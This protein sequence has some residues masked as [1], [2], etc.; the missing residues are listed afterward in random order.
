MSSGFISEKDVA[1][2]RRVRQENW[3]KNRK[4]DDPLEAPEEPPPD[5]RSLYDRLQEQRQ[6]KQE[7]YDEAHKK[8]VSAMQKNCAEEEMRA[9]MRVGEKKPTGGSGIKSHLSLLAGAIKRKHS[10]DDKTLEDVKA[11]KLPNTS[12][13]SNGEK[14]ETHS[15]KMSTKPGFQCIAVLPGLGVYTDSSDS[16]NNVDSDSDEDDTQPPPPQQPRDITGRIVKAP[17]QCSQSS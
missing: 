8:K 15:N 4:E 12:N 6:K 7:E 16:D 11:S 17:A 3:E 9:E 5:H 2:R 1:E 10:D 14:E 13:A